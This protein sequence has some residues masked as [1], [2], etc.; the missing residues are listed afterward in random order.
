[1][2]IY[3]YGNFNGKVVYCVRGVTGA[4]KG[5]PVLRV[6]IPKSDGGT[7]PLGVLALEDKI[8]QKAVVDSILSPIYEEHFLGYSY[9]FRPGRN[10]VSLRK[11]S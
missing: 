10:A 9:G 3:I 6:E 4:Y 1:M 7:R 2:I 5:Q 11:I 8:V